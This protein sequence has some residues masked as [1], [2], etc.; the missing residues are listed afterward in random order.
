MTSSSFLSDPG[1]PVVTDASVI[2][3][4]VATGT[5][6]EIINAFPNRFL[7]TTNVRR[8]LLEGRGRGHGSWEGLEALIV[9]GSIKPVEL[10]RSD[11]PV[12]RSLVEGEARETLD[13]GEAATIAY[14]VG[15]GAVALIDECKARRIC[16]ERFRELRLASTADVLL[17]GLVRD[18]LGVA[19]QR[20]AIFRALRD[21]KMQVVP[22]DRMQELVR[23]IGLVRAAACT[24]LP[25]WVRTMAGG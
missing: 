3:N 11:E 17:H 13:D 19:R 2:I 24:S 23:R 10:Q 1:A 21:A 18:G 6:P 12:Y 20:D 25:E 15:R 4:L 7:A 9:D 8:E 22:P 16:A 14:A 5:A